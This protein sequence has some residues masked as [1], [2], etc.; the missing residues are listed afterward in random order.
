[1]QDNEIIELYMHRDERAISE[2]E[3]KYG[4]YCKKIAFNIL[5]DVF[6]A[7]ECVND[8]YMRTWNAIPPTV[9]K[10]FSSFLA[11]ITRNLALDRYD[12]S[13]AKKRYAVS[14]SLEEL[15]EI[16]GE[17]NLSDEL[18]ISELGASISRF[19]SA[20]KPLSRRIF[21]KRY[22]FEES[23]QSIAKEHGITVGCV[24]VTLLRIR[25]R[26]AKFLKMEGF[27]L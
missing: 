19:L 9:P 2:T 7:E 4:A 21:I 17:E 22:F 6:D 8:A 11:K 24:K 26:L 15:S 25:T 14:E 27:F 12:S 20:E 1:M 23:L 16:I 3:Q 13:R 10:I 5:Y 18:E